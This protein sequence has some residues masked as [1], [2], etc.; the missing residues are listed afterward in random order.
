[1]SLGSLSIMAETAK[2][3]GGKRANRWLALVVWSVVLVFLMVRAGAN[4]SD[5]RSAS[6]VCA[7]FA[8]GSGSTADSAQT[9][10]W[11]LA[12]LSNVV[13]VNASADA[14]R[15]LVVAVFDEEVRVLGSTKI[16]PAD[17][18]SPIKDLSAAVDS[19]L[20]PSRWTNPVPA[21]DLAG[22]LPD[23]ACV[24]LVSDG[25]L[26]APPWIGGE[27]FTA[28]LDASVLRLAA[29]GIP[30]IVIALH[31][32]ASE[33][34]RGVAQ[35]TGGAYLLDPSADVLR[36]AIATIKTTP[37]PATSTPTTPSSSPS[38]SPL[39]STT[40]A[41]EQE[42]DERGVDGI[43]LILWLVGAIICSAIVAYFVLVI[44]GHPRLVGTLEIES[45]R[46]EKGDAHRPR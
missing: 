22:G 19:A 34:W 4:A 15:S 44:R 8:D 27:D 24:I 1:M 46:K 25:S 21:L 9:R 12:Q 18:G 36:S 42:H 43:G 20:R 10:A 14:D 17:G 3:R 16:S 41:H 5:G 23:L 39:P 33:I 7:V 28:T 30:V 2:R 37:T 38:P 45:P 6:E 31:D 35:K 32:D 11:L 29:R 40:M 13:A 26:D